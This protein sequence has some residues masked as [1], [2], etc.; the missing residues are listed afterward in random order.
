LSLNYFNISRF[1]V[2]MTDNLETRLHKP[3]LE[4]VEDKDDFFSISTL[5]LRYRSKHYPF[6]DYG[7]YKVDVMK[8]LLPPMTY[9]EARQ[10]AKN[11]GSGEFRPSSGPETFRV[12]RTLFVGASRYSTQDILGPYDR[13]I[14][15]KNRFKE[16]WADSSSIGIYSAFFDEWSK[17]H[18]SWAYRSFEEKISDHRTFGVVHAESTPQESRCSESRSYLEA[19]LCDQNGMI[20][21]SGE[22][23]ATFNDALCSMLFDPDHD[24]T[25]FLLEAYTDRK[26]SVFSCK[27]DRSPVY[28][29]VLSLDGIHIMPEDVPLPRIGIRVVGEMKPGWNWDKETY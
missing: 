8:E 4:T 19:G 2:L 10:A 13:C 18:P 1:N 25:R 9:A 6:G 17:D 15:L 7:F 14:R 29:V 27:R 28:H 11:S 22:M 12:L 24:T 23:S 16:Q 20:G 26:P 3:M 5:G 21:H